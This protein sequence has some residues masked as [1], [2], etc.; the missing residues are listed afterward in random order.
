VVPPAAPVVADR[1]GVVGRAAVRRAAI[2]PGEG[3]RPD[4]PAERGA[5][6]WVLTSSMARWASP[7]LVGAALDVYGPRP[8]TRRSRCDGEAEPQP[9]G[10]AGLPGSV[11]LTCEVC[12]LPCSVVFGGRFVSLILIRM[13]L[14]GNSKG[15]SRRIGSILRKMC[16]STCGGVLRVLDGR[17]GRS[18]VRRAAGFQRPDHHPPGCSGWRGGEEGSPG[19]CAGGVQVAD[20]NASGR[21]GERVAGQRGGEVAAQ[22][23]VAAVVGVDAVGGEADGGVDAGCSGGQGASRDGSPSPW[24]GRRRKRGQ[25]RVGRRCVARGGGGCLTSGSRWTPQPAGFAGSRV[26]PGRRGRRGR[27]GG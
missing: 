25:R 9:R 7:V 2:W 17:S 11:A 6:G 15:I 20:V 21:A 12:P 3:S 18:P 1:E 23:V 16:T 22:L 24:L 4:R 5:A 27:R 13:G 8:C 26:S 14:A 10:R 19:G